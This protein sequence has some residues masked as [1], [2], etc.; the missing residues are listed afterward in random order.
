MTD[1][2]QLF[3]RYKW[4]LLIIL[5]LILTFR[6][7]RMLSETPTSRPVSSIPLE[8]GPQAGFKVINQYPH[9]PQAFTQ[10]LVYHEDFLYESTG[11]YG[12]SSLRKVD[13]LS[14]E[15]LKMVPIQADYFAE[16]LTLWRD[17][18]IQLTW[19]EGAGLVYDLTSFER[20]HAFNYAGEGWGLTHDGIHLILSDG[21]SILRFLDPDTF[22][23]VRQIEVQ[24]QNLPVVNL[25]ELEYIQGEIYANIWQT[26]T[27]IRIN[28]ADG[29]LFGQIDLTG[30]L[31]NTNLTASAN[32][33]NGIAYD[34]TTDHLFVTGKLWPYLYEI[35]LV[36]LAADE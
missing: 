22:E 21:T 10:G 23:V 4:L 6:G 33:L 20:V 34:A 32:V 30:L 14:G 16:G 18:L 3:K 13:L 7:V 28:P 29:S 27:I 1:P 24:D 19:K 9:D 8:L 2:K 5:A 31:P 15:V 26:D 11:L 36:N 25:N 35:A 12:S 17:H